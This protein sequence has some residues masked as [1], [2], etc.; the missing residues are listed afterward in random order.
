MVAIT[1]PDVAFEACQQLVACK[2]HL[3]STAHS[4]LLPFKLLSRSFY[5]LS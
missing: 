4:E 1:R 5:E 2:V 3:C